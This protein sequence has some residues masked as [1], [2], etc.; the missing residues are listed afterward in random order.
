MPR[1]AEQNARI[2]DERREEI[3]RAGL[4]VF[5]RRGFDATKI[6]DI[7]AAARMSHGL[8]YRYFPSKEAAFLALVEQAVAGAVRITE[9]ALSGPESPAS[10]LERLIEQMFDGVR[11]QPEY[12]SLILQAY[13]TGTIPD[14]AR[15]V[16]DRYGEQT[17]ENVARLIRQGQDAGQVRSGDATELATLVLATVQGLTVNRLEAHTHRRPFPRART[18]I[19]LLQA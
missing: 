15:R 14:A 10:R 11:T 1:T 17:L 5:A 3:L 13:A 12:P 7:A 18:L 19:H 9:Q 16:L 4:A 6:A 8:I 2:R